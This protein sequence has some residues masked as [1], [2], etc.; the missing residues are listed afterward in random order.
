MLVQEGKHHLSIVEDLI[1]GDS[2]LCGAVIDFI[3]RCEKGKDND[4]GEF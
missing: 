3:I 1:D 2:P 4:K